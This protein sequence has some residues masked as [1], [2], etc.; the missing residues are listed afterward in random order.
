SLLLAVMPLRQTL[1][2][3]I[4]KR[5]TDLVKVLRAVRVDKGK[6]VIDGILDESD[7]ENAPS[8]CDFVQRQP[9]DG[10][11]ATEETT[12]KVVFDDEYIYVAVR[13]FD[14]DPGS[15]TGHLTRRDEYSPSDYIA[16]HFDSYDDNLTAFF[17]GVNPQ[18]V[19]R[20]GFLYDGNSCDW[21]WNA[22]WEVKTRVDEEGWV[23][24]FAIPFSQLRYS[25]RD[26]RTWGFQ[27]LRVI[28]R[29]NENILWSPRPMEESQI[30]SCF[31]TLEGLDGIP[32]SR[33]L[34]ILPYLV[35]NA[36]RYG[37]SDDNPFYSNEFDPFGG[38]NPDYR[39]G[40]DVKYGITSDMTL[41]MTINPD[42][43]QVEQDPSE[44]NLTA[45]E[46]YFDERRP[47]FV[48][49]GNIFDFSLGLGDNMSEKLFYS[50]RIGRSP[51]LCTDDAYRMRYVDDWNE[52]SPRFTKILGA[53]KVT[54]RT[55]GGWS[56]GLLEA[57]T[58]KEDAR[59]ELPGGERIG[60]GVEP[61]TSYTVMRARREFNEGRSAFGG[62]LTN[63]SRDLDGDNF[64]YLT[65]R[66]IT[67][68]LDYT[69][70]WNEDRYTIITRVMG[71]HIS[72]SERALIE[73]Q[74]S[75]IRYYQRPDADHLGVDSTL[76]HMEGFSATVWGGK[77]S[78]EPWRFGI[79]FN[80][81]SPGFEVNDIGFS[82]EADNTFGVLWVGY[83]DFEAGEIVR[84]WNLNFNHWHGMNY[85]GDYN[86]WG[87]NVNGYLL[88]VNN[89]GIYA[90]LARNSACQ[91]NTL[92]RGGPSILYPGRINSWHGF[93]SDDRKMIQFT[94]D[95][96]GSRS[97]EGWWTYEINPAVTVRP[98]GRLNIS[99]RP[100]YV[101]SSDDMQ[102]VDCVEDT[103]GDRYILGHLERRTISLTTRLDFTITP[104]MTIQFYG[105]P[106]IT[107]GEYTDFREV[108]RPHAAE[109]QDRFASYDYSGYDNPD[110]NFKQLRTNLVFRWE[111]DPGSTIFL[112]W[113][114][115][116]TDY[117]EEYGR[118]GL[119]R[120]MD[121]LF[122][123][124]SD[125]TFLVKF[126]K[127]FSI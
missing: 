53:A 63:V 10:K 98:S 104:E 115:G 69:H 123:L 56:I 15:I 49:G 11:P 22:V 33:R 122:S 66:A 25:S 86:G 120:D 12:V 105:M 59:V 61:M 75:P 6:I 72:G 34:E 74:R 107:A 54:G 78:G 32:S 19:K 110:F 16:V 126:N 5:E 57:V 114:T 76:T 45:F 73:A 29:R 79:G 93:H 2:D 37:D 81:R 68:G 102:Y 47:F 51:Q 48:E 109:Y 70:R 43:G 127:W 26:V 95:G 13:A 103:D 90:G 83:R 55:A 106:F 80:T 121:R 44:F 50:R 4:E 9:D 88:F 84:N 1:A 17:F 39:L 24:E 41:S 35:I 40:A 124:P 71:S 97:D 27:V 52:D 112:V 60:V 8:G 82:R 46:S 31:G 100:S 3:N 67:G 117:E 62:I 38:D 89:W 96:W 7:W 58:D 125:N 119:G 108:V 94:Y 111:F 99:F 113:S 92:L 23:A 14:S 21:N 91:S 20:D 65:N 118:F 18:G 85:G 30:V 116:T 101:I 36:D 28:P 77:F 64:D 87:G 42:F